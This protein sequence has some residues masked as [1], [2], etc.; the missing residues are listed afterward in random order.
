MPPVPVPGHP[1]AR[2]RYAPKRHH[3]GTWLVLTLSILAAVILALVTH[4]KEE[5]SQKSTP[6]IWTNPKD[7]LDYALI[8]AGRFQMGCVPND[9][10]CE[11]DEKPRH[12]VRL[13]E[14]FRMTSSEVTVLSWNRFVKEKAYRSEAEREGFTY[15]WKKGSWEPRRGTSWINP[16]FVQKPDHPVVHVSWNDARD[17]CEWAGGRLPTEAEWEYAARAGA[18]S[19]IFAWGNEPPAPKRPPVNMADET[20]LEKRSVLLGLK[21]YSD[22]FEATSPARSFERNRFGLYGMSGNVWEWTSDW[23]SKDAYSNAR[24][25]DP[26]GPESGKEKVLRGGSYV[27]QIQFLRLS[28]RSRAS[29]PVR[30]AYTGFRCVVNV[31]TSP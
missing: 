5:S 28:F 11:G 12:E 31:G 25:R 9:A 14:S 4:D 30:N 18:G 3:G 19:L 17:Y 1:A 26:L 24:A 10:E 8:P 20:A 7:G 15:V 27:S 21:G 29:P 6:E 16:G 13:T 22:G 2:Q 23:Y